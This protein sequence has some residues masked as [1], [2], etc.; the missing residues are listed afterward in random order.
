VAGRDPRP[1]WHLAGTPRARQFLVLMTCL[2]PHST[3]QPQ[4]PP[5][6][7]SGAHAPPLPGHMPGTCSQVRTHALILSGL[8]GGLGHGRG[9]LGGCGLA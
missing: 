2:A 5:P 9:R 4:H 3:S 6:L 7:P 1:I 8:R